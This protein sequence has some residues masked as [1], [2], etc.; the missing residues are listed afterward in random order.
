MAAGAGQ[1]DAEREETIAQLGRFARREHE[2]DIRQQEPKRRDELHQLTV[3]HGGQRLKF[4]GART[5]P[6]EGDGHLRLPAMPQEVERVRGDAQGLAPP[7]RQ[8]IERTDAQPTEARIIRALGRF[9][10]PVEIPLRPRRVHSLIDGAVVSLLIHDQTFRTGGD[11]GPVFLRLHRADFE[12]EAGPLR[13]QRSDTGRHVVARD[14]LGMLAGDQQQIAETLIAQ[15]PGFAPHFLDRE[16]HA[17]NRVVAGEAA[18]GAVVDALVGKIQRRKEA[19]DLAKPLPGEGLGAA[20]QR[21]QQLAG[22]GRDQPGKV[23]Q[24]QLRLSQRGL[25]FRQRSRAGGLLQ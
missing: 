20:A 21:L 2:A 15:R 25:G 13:V 14:E 18:V 16:R 5:Q 17:Q 6:W 3:G 8:A 7:V 9:Q 22:D 23:L 4:A 24:R 19:D 12:R 11:D 10:P 1:R